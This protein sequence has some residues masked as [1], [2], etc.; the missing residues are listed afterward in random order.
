[1]TSIEPVT[2][3]GIC[4]ALSDAIEV[5]AAK[6]R[7]ASPYLSAAYPYAPGRV[8]QSVFG[9]LAALAKRL[10][11]TVR[12]AR[13]PGAREGVWGCTV[14][15]GGD[16]QSGIPPFSMYLEPSLSQASA[17]RV[18][19]HELSHVVLNHPGRT[20]QESAAIA[21]VRGRYGKDEHEESKVELA[22]AALCQVAGIPATAECP[23][24]IRQHL[25]REPVT[26]DDKDAA[27]L[28]ARVIVPAVAG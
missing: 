14:G 15:A 20:P 23:G 9:R 27:L 16:P 18:F 26:Q 22:A 13:P 3:P 24:Y 12:V 6:S 25:G 1:M 7:Y 11:Y 21:Y 8:H 10:G 19:C 4:Q 28:A 17:A 5:T 2:D